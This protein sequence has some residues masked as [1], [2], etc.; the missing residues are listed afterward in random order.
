MIRTLLATA[1]LLTPLLLSGCGKV[2]GA[3]RI[4]PPDQITYPKI[5]P[6]H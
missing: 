6:T 5:Y 2:G 3:T 4:G 1:L